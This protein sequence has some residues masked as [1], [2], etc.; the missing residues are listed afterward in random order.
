[1]FH[2]CGLATEFRC[3][4]VEH[5]AVSCGDQHLATKLDKE[6]TK[7]DEE[8]G[9][10][11]AV[12]HEGFLAGQLR[13]LLFKPESDEQI[14]CESHQFPEDKQLHQAVGGDDAEHGEGEC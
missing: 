2:D 9:I 10:A 12:H 14:A 1:M 5:T 11:Y 4:G 3:N 13:P 6:D 7:A 8:S